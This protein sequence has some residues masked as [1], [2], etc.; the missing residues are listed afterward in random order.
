MTI[1]KCQLTLFYTLNDLFVPPKT[2]GI[3]QSP[4]K[5][6]N[7]IAIKSEYL[8]RFRPAEQILHRNE[9]LGTPGGG[10]VLYNV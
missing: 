1:R 10:G 4:K 2:I 9:P 6:L 7:F 3:N 8:R 5:S